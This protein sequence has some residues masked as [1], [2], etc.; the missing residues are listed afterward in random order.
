MREY[1]KRNIE[2]ELEKVAKGFPVIM[3][4]G[5]RQVGKSTLLNNL[6]LTTNQEISNVSLDDLMTRKRAIEDPALFIS[7]L[8]TPVIIDEFQYAPNI[9]SYIKIAVDEARL[10]SFKEEGVQYNGL[11]YLTGS[12]PF[13]TMK[14][15]SESLA[16]RVGLLD[17]YGLSLRENYGLANEDIF[18]PDLEVL[19]KR[20][21]INKM[22]LARNIWNNF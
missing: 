13:S 16:G 8:K 7:S 12:Q 22:T 2:A 21:Q 1:I 20:K 6:S 9:L 4:T 11:Y 10:K 3:V 19:K 17:L 15:I 14:N 18:L 5:P